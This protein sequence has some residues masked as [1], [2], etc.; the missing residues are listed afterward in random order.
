MLWDLYKFVQALAYFLTF[1]LC[2]GYTTQLT[3]AEAMVTYKDKSSEEESCQVFVPFVSDVRLWTGTE[4]ETEDIQPLSLSFGH[5]ANSF[6]D[7]SRT[8][9]PSPPSSPN[10]SKYSFDSVSKSED[11]MELQL[12]YWIYDKFQ[13]KL[14]TSDRKSESDKK[15]QDPKSSIRTNFRGLLISHLSSSSL[16]A[17]S[18]DYHYFNMTYTTK[19][20]RPKAVLK[21]GKKK[22]KGDSDTKTTT[23]DGISRLIC[24]AKS[25]HPLKV[26]ENLKRWW[27]TKLCL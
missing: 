3:I 27:C 20:K 11:L 21:I 18:S 5:G 19:E 22:E 13:G 23:I 25:S 7:R 14:D 8:D 1:T 6:L 24:M 4:P 9:R 26:K 16:L 12:D 10:I 2:L 17:H 15:K